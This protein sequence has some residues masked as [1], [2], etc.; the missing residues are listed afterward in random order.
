MDARKDFL[1]FIKGYK[2]VALA[3][4]D[5]QPQVASDNLRVWIH[6][7]GLWN[8]LPDSDKAK[9]FDKRL[10]GSLCGILFDDIFGLDKKHYNSFKHSLRGETAA[11]VNG[12]YVSKNDPTA[13]AIVVQLP[14]YYHRDR[15][16]ASA[17]GSGVGA[18][19]TVGMTKLI[20]V[21]YNK[22]EK[23][24]CILLDPLCQTLKVNEMEKLWGE[25]E[26]QYDALNEDSI[27][28]AAAIR[29]Q[30]Y[31]NTYS[32]F[33]PT[34][35]EGERVNLTRQTNLNTVGKKL[36]PI[37][38]E[39]DKLLTAYRYLCTDTHEVIKSEEFQN[40]LSSLNAEEYS[41]LLRILA[42]LHENSST[43]IGI[44]WA[45]ERLAKPPT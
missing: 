36:L 26:K 35:S 32:N 27:N 37:I 10:Q 15:L 41:K 29:F 40:E 31:K 38:N 43:G 19:T 3:C 17:I 18:L 8:Q 21:G 1:K 33:R 45:F 12:L 6:S 24:V 20:Q 13:Y 28:I 4:D 30:K 42:N 7:D 22:V 5:Y 34:T 9:M 16:I 11:G 44:I 23:D 25:F 2:R 39:Q 14:K